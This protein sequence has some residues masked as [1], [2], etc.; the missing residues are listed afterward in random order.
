MENMFSS[1]DL[2]YKNIS[3][4][5]LSRILAFYLFIYYALVYALVLASLRCQLQQRPWSAL[6][7]FCWCLFYKNCLLHDKDDLG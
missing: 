4:L 1:V 6:S 3:I 7:V 5:F 2:K